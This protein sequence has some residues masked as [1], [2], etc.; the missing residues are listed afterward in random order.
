MVAVRANV[1]CLLDLGVIGIN[2]ENRVVKRWGFYET[3]RQARR[4]AAIR[5]AA[6]GKGTALFINA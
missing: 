1:S 3:D 2:V 5:Q 6:K 4:I